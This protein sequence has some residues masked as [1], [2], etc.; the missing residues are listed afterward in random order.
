MSSPTRDLEEEMKKHAVLWAKKSMDSCTA[1]RYLCILKVCFMLLC[2]HKDFH[3]YLFSESEKSEENFYIYKKKKKKVK[4][5]L[6]ICFGMSSYRGKV[7]LMVK[8]LPACR[9]PKRCRFDPW[10]GKILCRRKWQPTPIFLAGKSQTE[11]PSGLQSMGSQRVSHVWAHT[12]TVTEAVSTSSTEC[13]QAL[14]LGTTFS[15]SASTVAVSI[16]AYLNH[17]CIY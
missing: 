3:Y 13:H 8:N 10:V 15:I 2:F 11:E 5:V 17:L 1:D 6:S 16:C 14:S 12:H 7:V 9:R 4:I